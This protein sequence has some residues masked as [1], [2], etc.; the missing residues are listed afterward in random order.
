MYTYVKNYKCYADELIRNKDIS[1]FLGLMKLLIIR[2]TGN[3][4]L[5]GFK[6][7]S[8]TCNKGSEL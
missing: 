4:S 1:M 6:K 2:F 5:T 3:Q 8:I 7:L